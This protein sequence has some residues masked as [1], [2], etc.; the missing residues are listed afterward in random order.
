MALLK[1]GSIQAVLINQTENISYETILAEIKN[2]DFVVPVFGCKI[3]NPIDLVKMNGADA[4]LV[5]PVSK[6][7]LFTLLDRLCPQAGTILIADDEAEVVRL[8]HR[9]LA[10]RKKDYRIL[11]APNGEISLELMREFHPDCVLLDL[12]MPEKDGMAVLREKMADSTMDGIK[13]II[14]SAHDPVGNVI[15]SQSLWVAKENGLSVRQMVSSIE[16]LTQVL[17]PNRWST[18]SIKQE[19]PSA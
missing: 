4:Y 8:Y 7:Q 14:T 9:M 13:V 17:A 15:V 1:T 3:Q 10:A 12:S 6:D 11:T 16:S 19:D 18:D 5:K 2:L